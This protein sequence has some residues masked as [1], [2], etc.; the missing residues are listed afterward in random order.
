VFGLVVLLQLH[1]P[2]LQPRTAQLFSNGQRPISAGG[3]VQLA[4]TPAGTHLSVFQARQITPQAKYL[5]NTILMLY[6]VSMIS[7]GSNAK[8][9]VTLLWFWLL[10]CQLLQFHCASASS[11]LL[12]ASVFWIEH[13]DLI[14]HSEEE[15]T[16]STQ[17]SYK[18]LK[19][20]CI[21]K[22]QIVKNKPTET[23]T[24]VTRDM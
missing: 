14:H 23:T 4:T 15:R 3:E 24:T 12:F 9:E 6:L 22:K 2:Y 18:Q 1:S 5:P 11:L 17:S 16:R 7:L 20:C 21:V 19:Q 8:L 10:C 13:W